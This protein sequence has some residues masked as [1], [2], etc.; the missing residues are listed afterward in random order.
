MR[1]FAFLFTVVFALTVFTQ[2]AFADGSEGTT[3]KKEMTLQERMKYLGLIIP[4]DMKRR[5][6]ELDR[7][8]PPVLLNP[9]DR[10]DWREMGGVTPVKDQGSCGSCW[11]FAGVG[12]IESA[13]LITDTVEWDLSE[14]QIM[15]CNRWGQGCYGGN[16]GT[17]YE[18]VYNYGIVQ[19]DCYPYQQS[20]PRPCRQDTCV[21]IVNID[22]DIS[23]P[24]SVPAIKNALLDAPVS[25][26]FYVAGDFRYDCTPNQPGSINHAIDIVGWD[27]T[28]CTNGAWICKNSWGPGW[29]DHGF[30]YINYSFCGI[31]NYTQRPIYVSRLPQLTYQPEA[32]TFNVPSGG[33]ASQT[34]TIGNTGDGDL[35]Y[36]IRL[37]RPTFQDEF[38]YFWFDSDNPQGPEYDWLDI[39]GVG[40]VVE[41]LHGN[42]D[43]GNTGPIDL[44][45]DFQHYGNTFNTI[46]VCSNG[47]ASFTDGT[48]TSSYNM[49]IPATYAPN[50][51][52]AP[53]WTDL[54]PGA[55]GDVY[56]YTNNADSAIISWEEVY[57]SWEEGIFTFQIV[58]VAPDTIVYQYESMGPEGRIDRATI[59]MENGT[60]TVGLEVSRNEIYTYGEK[61]VEFYLGDPPGEFDWLRSNNDH[62]T[63]WPQ[64]SWDITITCSAGDHPEGRYWGIINLYTNDPDSVHVDLLV[65][66]EIES[67]VTIEIIPD[68]PPVT[69]PTGGSFGFTGSLTNETNEHQTVDIWTM[70]IDHNGVARG[71]FKTFNNVGLSPHRTLSG[72]FNQRVP[73]VAPLG[74]YLYVAYCGA[75]PSEV[76]DS[77]YFGFEVIPGPLAKADEEGWVLTGSFGSGHSFTELPSDFALTRNY[78]NPFNANTT[79]HYQLPTTS[80]VKLEVYNLLGEKVGTLVDEEQEAGYKSVNWEASGYSSGIYFYK[81]SAGDKAFIKRMTLLR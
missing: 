65:T 54:D 68:N 67:P 63:I 55:G 42:P 66:M 24:N 56:Y 70:A 76:L 7:Q 50:D 31:G 20:S 3:P 34:L 11:C 69:V 18:H 58:L 22:G 79:I 5:F 30:F 47:W 72:D 43:N 36:R 73:N 23:I 19:E 38:G 26:C 14:Q 57:D 60:G 27:D 29:G 51:L 64:G 74:D 16:V 2:L 39:T 61:A 77:S 62:G 21:V 25:S 52:L 28:L 59:G 4:E 13:V 8:P 15:D 81:L 32:F 44:G 37:F 35:H 49:P 71:P 12:A 6:E 53:F 80:S 9:D 78:P 40:Q 45:F 41:F 48:S 46:C 17:V 75:Y 10:F 1:R 33:E